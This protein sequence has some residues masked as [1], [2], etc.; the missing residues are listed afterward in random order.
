MNSG[1]VYDS[2]DISNH[3]FKSLN[4]MVEI[5]KYTKHQGFRPFL[6]N[7]QERTEHLWIIQSLFKKKHEIIPKLP[8]EFLSMPRTLP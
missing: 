7:I 1:F 4:H 5:I 3:T 6:S 2:L 8:P